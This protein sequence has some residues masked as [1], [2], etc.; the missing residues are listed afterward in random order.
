MVHHKKAPTPG[1]SRMEW[2]AFFLR[3]VATKSVFFSPGVSPSIDSHD[4]DGP[5]GGE[6]D[7]PAQPLQPEAFFSRQRLTPRRGGGREKDSGEG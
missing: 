7:Q 1:K 3:S 6:A 2:G 4:L 5:G